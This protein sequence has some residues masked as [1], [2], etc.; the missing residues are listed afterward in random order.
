MEAGPGGNY[1]R[2]THSVDPTAILLV[3]TDITRNIS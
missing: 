2:Y 1:I 3:D